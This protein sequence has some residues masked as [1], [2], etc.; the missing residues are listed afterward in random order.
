MGKMT[1][2]EILMAVT[3]PLVWGMG[4]VFAKGAI[5]HFPPILL[6]A[7]R[8]TLTALVL[9]WFTRIP[10]DNLVKLFFIAIVA[11]AIQYS[12]TFTG[13][14]G[15]EAGIA[16]LIV[17][18]EVP[19]L[20]LLGALLLGEK[21][22]FRKWIGIVVAL[23]GVALMTQQGEFNGNLTSVMLVICGA[24]TWALGQ[25][26]IRNLKDIQGMQVTAWIAVFAAPQLFVMSAV[27]EHGQVDAIRHADAIVWGAVVYLGLVMTAFGYFLWNTLIRRHDVGRVAPFLLLL[28]FFSVIGG[29]LFLGEQP[30]VA[31]LIGGGVI[32]LGVAIITI[33]PTFLSRYGA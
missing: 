25:V 4:F 16:S 23:C 12:L 3:V 6:M 11:A 5:A 21:P 8:F 26:M 9:V 14:K 10:H 18:L 30:S 7:L 2:L 29:M 31:K 19:F 27:F 15:L 24:F 17:Q 22:E 32:L 1:P 28:P 20:V 13:L 33:R